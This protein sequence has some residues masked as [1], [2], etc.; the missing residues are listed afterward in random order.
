MSNEEAFSKFVLFLMICSGGAIYNSFLFSEKNYSKE[1]RKRS[2][3]QLL[4]DGFFLTLFDLYIENMIITFIQS[5]YI[6]FFMMFIIFGIT[7]I[8]G[9]YNQYL[10]TYILIGVPGLIL[11]MTFGL[12]CIGENVEI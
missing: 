8:E 3:S 4:K 10:G 6:I 12:Y 1:L 7:G 2:E 11:G 9:V 5:L